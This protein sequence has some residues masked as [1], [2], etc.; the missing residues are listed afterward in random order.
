MVTGDAPATAAIVAHAVG[1]D[2]TTCP[3]G[4]IPEDINPGGVR[5]GQCLRPASGKDKGMGAQT[6]L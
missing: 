1:L 4:P 5:D 3:L 6:L 2:G